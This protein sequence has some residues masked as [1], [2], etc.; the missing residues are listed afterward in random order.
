[1]RR[2]DKELVVENSEIYMYYR[3]RLINIALAQFEWHGL[4]ETCD[5]LYF[6]RAL[7]NQGSAAMYVPEGCDFWLST[8]FTYNGELSV[9]GYPTRITGVPA[10]GK[11]P[12][13][14]D[15]EKWEFLYDNMTKGSLLPKIDMYA[16]LLWEI[17]QT[18][19]SNLKHQNTPWL[20][21]TTRNQALTFKNFFNRIF[22][23][24]PV[25][26]LKN[27]E[28][29]DD[30]I[31]TFDMQVDFKG[32]DILDAL[33]TTWA[34]ALSML[35]ITAKQTK[36]ERLLQDELTI[37][38]MEDLLSLN[39]RLLNRVDFCNKMNKKYGMNLSVNLSSAE[40]QFEIYPGDYAMR[41]LDAKPSDNTRPI[42]ESK[43]K[44]SKSIINKED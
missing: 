34:E 18:F 28:M 22:G 5:R 19:R 35:G 37:N 9:Y 14:T 26:E 31:K 23:F 42:F 16:R 38:R 3:E 12:I 21:L 41:N 8:G 43:D 36:K 7:L 13:K 2:Q 27:T 4:P 32:N 24:Q 10:N 25:I 30:S 29:F 33:K 44:M 40:T 15:P 6:E 39:A 17:H 11:G 1:M 20:V